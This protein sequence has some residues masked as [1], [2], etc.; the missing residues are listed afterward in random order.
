MDVTIVGDLC[1]RELKKERVRRMDK[2][3]E[4]WLEVFR[5]AEMLAPG[6][7]WR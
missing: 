2:A 3:F 1:V 7:L 4:K 6:L 5:R